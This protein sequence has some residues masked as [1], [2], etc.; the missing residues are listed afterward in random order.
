VTEPRPWLEAGASEIEQALL[1][2]GRDDGPRQG[3]DLRILATI[4]ESPPPTVKP[5]TFTRWAKVGFIVVV[6]GGAAV[7]TH[8]LSRPG[9]VPPSPP[10]ARA[11]I[12]EAMS[13]VAPAEAP[14][15]GKTLFPPEIGEGLKPA[16]REAP[17][18]VPRAGNAQGRRAI[19]A[20]R[21]RESTPRPNDTPLDLSLGE[22]TRALDSARE[23]LDAHRPAEVLRQLDEYR[24]RFP[25]GRLRPEAMILRLG[26][27]VQ[28]GKQQAAD[29]LASRL[30]SDPAYEPY[31]PRIQSWLR[32]A[33][34]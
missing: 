14:E 18:P 5:G 24:H 28:A 20:G 6:A 25:Q 32:E 3:A 23:A 22:E 7:V 30:L 26:A 27:L 13:V 17:P 9:A 15:P 8:Q 12:A 31:V 1:R 19:A 16:G 11:V 4:R 21:S 2:A 33:K 34:P 29:S 10:P